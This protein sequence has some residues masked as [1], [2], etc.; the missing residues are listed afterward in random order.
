VPGLSNSAAA[1]GKDRKAAAKTPTAP[2]ARCELELVLGVQAAGWPL[3]EQDP[4]TGGE[5]CRARR[6]ERGGSAFVS[7]L[8]VEEGREEV[9]QQPDLLDVVTNPRLFHAWAEHPTA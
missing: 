1:I 5:T 3:P 8:G 6:I 4:G 7:M 9:L 2:V